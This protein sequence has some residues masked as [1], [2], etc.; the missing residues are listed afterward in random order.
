MLEKEVPLDKIARTR[1]VKSETI[2]SHIEDLVLEGECPDISYLKHELK[3]SELDDIISAFQKA[4]TNT[5]S[6]VY[7]LLLKQKKKPTYLKIRLAR[8]FL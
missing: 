1:G 3:R 6:P 5:L 7:N 8:L 4:G 2:I